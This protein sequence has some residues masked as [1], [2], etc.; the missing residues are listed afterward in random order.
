M[1]D[2]ENAL[3]G[4]APMLEIKANVSSTREDS[5]W[6]KDEV[7]RLRAEIKAASSEI[8]DWDAEA[9]AAQAL[10]SLK[11]DV[12]AKKAR[13]IECESYLDDAELDKMDSEP[14]KSED[15]DYEASDKAFG[16]TVRGKK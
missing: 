8:S 11:A 3:K 13:L 10:K 4:V 16:K 1:S 14:K 9:V 12:A 6:R 5:S 2:L 7:K 15:D